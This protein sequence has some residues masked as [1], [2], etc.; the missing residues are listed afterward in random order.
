MKQVLFYVFILIFWGVACKTPKAGSTKEV[1]D[2]QMAS[3]AQGIVGQVSEVFGNQMPMVGA[4]A[5]TPKPFKT[6]VYIYDSTH[7]SRVKQIGTSPLYS[8]VNT[9]L[10]QKLDTNEAGQFSAALEVGTYS[11]FVLKGGAFFANQF[12]EKNNIGICRVEVGKQT[13]L[14]ITVNTDAS[15]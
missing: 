9:R 5:P 3:Q 4:P 12:D 1:A 10:V 15:Y 13:R 2:N 6:T 7:S 11:V 14:Q 8:V